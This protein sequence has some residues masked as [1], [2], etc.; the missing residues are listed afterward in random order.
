MERFVHFYVS[1][2]NTI[3]EVNITAQIFLP[4]MYQSLASRTTENIY[5]RHCCLASRR[6]CKVSSILSY[7]FTCL[8]LSR[9]TVTNVIKDPV[10]FPRHST[11]I[12]IFYHWLCKIK[13]FIADKISQRFEEGGDSDGSRWRRSPPKN[14]KIFNTLLS[15]KFA[16]RY[17]VYR[18]I[19]ILI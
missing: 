10:I 19:M 15:E 3:I 5:H 9:V 11:S 4:S 13:I 17:L 16:R 12:S 18:V 2:I 7:L 1:Q 6:W 14:T 8:L